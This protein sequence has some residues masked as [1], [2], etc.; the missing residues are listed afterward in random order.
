MITIGVIGAGVMGERLVRAA[1]DHAADTVEIAGIWDPSAEAMARMAEAFPDVARL[2]SADAVVAS[3]ECV[4]IASPPATHIGHARAVLEEGRALFCEKPL[5][6]DVI[7][8]RGFVAAA[9]G[10]RAAVN[11]PFAS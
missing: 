9:T 2:E 1:L 3:A 8:A 10:V 6:V 11:F 4:Y 7:E 5:A